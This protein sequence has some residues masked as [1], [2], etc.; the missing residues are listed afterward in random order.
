M[1]L[2]QFSELSTED[3][4][5]DSEIVHSTQKELN[6]IIILRIN[7]TLLK[8][9]A[10]L[11]L[12]GRKTSIGT[13]VNRREGASLSFIVSSNRALIIGGFSFASL[14]FMSK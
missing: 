7:F 5:Y 13:S 12:R 11:C 9:Y 14:L 2:R 1:T 6:V 8:K 10:C 3:D 4:N